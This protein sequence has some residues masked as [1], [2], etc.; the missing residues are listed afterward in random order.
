MKSTSVPALTSSPRLP[1][2]NVM[3][4]AATR[5]RNQVAG[6]TTCPRAATPNGMV[7]LS[8][9]TRR[10]RETLSGGVRGVVGVCHQLTCTIQ[11]ATPRD[12]VHVSTFAGVTDVDAS[13]VPLEA[14]PKLAISD[15]GCR[16][17]I[18]G[19]GNGG[20]DI[21]A[22]NATSNTRRVTPASDRKAMGSDYLRPCPLSAILLPRRR[23]RTE[24][25]ASPLAR[26]SAA[27]GRRLHCGS[28]PLQGEDDIQIKS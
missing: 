20:I 12:F 16:R 14:G 28:P 24:K 19:A 26:T 7:M 2:G 1:E 21:H 13:R 5:A 17:I 8:Q 27:K 9:G 18:S 4:G 22:T 3:S 23:P 25:L 6:S 15:D 11:R 10:T